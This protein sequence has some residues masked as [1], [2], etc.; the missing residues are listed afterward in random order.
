MFLSTKDILQHFLIKNR[1]LSF[2]QACAS[3]CTNTPVCPTTC[4]ST[5]CKRDSPIYVEAKSKIAKPE[6]VGFEKHKLFDGGI[7]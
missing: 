4:S 2:L 3:V 7:K 5:C 1:M 6:D